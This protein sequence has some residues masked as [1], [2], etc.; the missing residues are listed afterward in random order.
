MPATAA[1]SWSSGSRSSLTASSLRMRP[2]FRAFVATWA[3]GRM[4]REVVARTPWIGRRVHRVAEVGELEPLREPQGRV[5]R[6]AEALAPVEL[7]RRA[8]EAEHA[9]LDEVVQGQPMALVPAGDGD[10]EAQVGIDEPVLGEEVTALDA[11]GELDLLRGLQEL[12]AVR[13][14]QELLERVGVD[15]ALMIFK[16]LVLALGLGQDPPVK[17]RFVQSELYPVLVAC[18]TAGRAPGTMAVR[19]MVR[20]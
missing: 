2:T 14:L 19:R 7:L 1:I 13:P 20:N 5:R 6:E 11:L 8:D 4:E 18:T 15:V 9:L 3:G 10:D 12:V 17:Y 16:D